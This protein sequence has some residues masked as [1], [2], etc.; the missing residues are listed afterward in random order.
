MIPHWRRKFI[1]L[2]TGQALSILSSMISQFALTWYLTEKTGST[3][4][5]SLSMLAMMLPMALLSPFTGSFADRFDRRFIMAISDGAIG[6]ISLLL[7]AL[8]SQGELALLPILAVMLLRSVGSAFHS[9]CLQAVTPLIAPSE[10]LAKCA[11]WSQGIQTVSMLLS[12]ALAASLYASVPL[13]WIL[14][15]D[16]LGA[17]FA[18]VGLLAAKLPALRVGEP[19]QKLRLWQ[20]TRAGLRVLRSHTW[21]WQLYLVFALFSVAF[22]PVAALF[23]LMSMGY[24]GRDAAA[25]AVIETVFSAGMLAGSILLGVWG[26]TKNKITAMVASILALG[27]LLALAGLLPPGAFWLFAVLSGL[28]GVVVP[29]FGSLFMALLQEKVEPEYLGRV[30]GL[31]DS[32]MGLA[33]PLGLLPAAIFGDYTGPSFWFLLAGIL[34]IAAGLLALA[35]PTVRNC[36]RA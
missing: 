18:I 16:T 25:A 1:T 24:F 7:V 32:V 6:L 21:L 17:V 15:L 23:P 22:M 8:A 33:S 12:P 36:D 13:H 27:A 4:V 19:G 31:S 3:A 34:I 26:G 9:P 10:S 28:M 2:W 5:L 11:G 29:F 20:D 30:L 35:L 14:L